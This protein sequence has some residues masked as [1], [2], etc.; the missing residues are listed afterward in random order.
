MGMRAHCDICGLRCTRN[1]A[2]E[3]G[4]YVSR[5][6]PTGTLTV[7]ITVVRAKGDSPIICERCVR[8]TAYHGES[9]TNGDN[10]S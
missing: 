8:L 7:R 3:S 1:V 6:H 4:T 9:G 5:T 10:P 2:G